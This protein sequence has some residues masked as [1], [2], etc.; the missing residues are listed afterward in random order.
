MTSTNDFKM[1]WYCLLEDGW[2][3]T[4][5]PNTENCV[6]AAWYWNDTVDVI[7][8][9]EQEFIRITSNGDSVH[10]KKM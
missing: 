9:S 3:T 8:V 5:L 6:K 1:R 2:K 7:I 4:T 10:Y